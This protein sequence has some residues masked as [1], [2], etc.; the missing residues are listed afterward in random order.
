MNEKE[1]KVNDFITLKLEEEGTVIY[2]GGELFQQCKYLIFNLDKEGLEKYDEIRSI[3]EL[4]Q[5]DRS[6][7]YNQLQIPLEVEF[8][9]HC[10]N[11]QAWE[12]NDYDTRLLHRSLA[13][14]L[15]EELKNLGDVKAATVFN[16]E[17][18][19]RFIEGNQAVINFIFEQN[20][21]EDFTSEE[22][23]VLFENIKEPLQIKY[24]NLSNLEIEHLP[25]S[26]K[27]FQ[28]IRVL[29]L[30]RNQISK[31]PK[32]IRE[33]YK[34]ERLL[35]SDN[36]LESL[37][38]TIGDLFSLRE[39]D[40]S[41]NNLTCLPDSIGNLTSMVNL[42]LD[43]NQLREIPESIGNF[44]SLRSLLLNK[45]NLIYLPESIGN[46]GSLKTME[47]NHNKLT[48]LPESIG[49]LH[50][51]EKLKLNRNRIARLPESIANLKSLKE[52]RL[53]GNNLK[54]IPRSLLRLKK[55]QKVT[56]D[57]NQISH[58]PKSVLMQ[59]HSP[60]FGLKNNALSPSFMKSIS[61]EVLVR[62]LLKRNKSGLAFKIVV[63]GDKYA[64]K[65]SLILR[66]LHHKFEDYFLKWRK[67]FFIKDIHIFGENL[68]KL[69]IWKHFGGG[70]IQ[71]LQPG[72]RF[73][74]HAAL[75]LIDLTREL[76]LKK[77]KGWV[78]FLREEQKR[79]PIMLIGTKADLKDQIKVQKESLISIKE[80][81]RMNSMFITSAKTG[82]NIEEVFNDLI[83]IVI[84]YAFFG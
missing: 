30:S 38:K 28:N 12:E 17:V 43:R 39:L 48:S 45:N 22:L 40:I 76:N 10:S 3:D 34:L 42:K 11:L 25:N 61:L 5:W 73:G 7:E 32:S 4:E 19:K 78:D 50:Q 70:T 83:N 16:G 62:N 24:L 35:I 31:L 47:I 1:F 2:V 20:Y 53:E 51:V 14:P 52:V 44:T 74:A 57:D 26:I 67:Y 29:D 33:L 36:R 84:R 21:L 63:A 80:R 68:V 54:E 59:K 72:F 77:I 49:N 46:L 27:A 56:L 64:G 6:H 8:W 60:F 79:L 58:F 9:G 23:R 55:L 18:A 15:L 71:K 65:S 81:F 41:N 66:Y 82:K 13:F 37:P 75:L 69:L